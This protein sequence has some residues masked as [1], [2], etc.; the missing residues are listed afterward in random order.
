[1]QSLTSWELPH[2][3][4]PQPIVPHRAQ[5]EIVLWCAEIAL[6]LVD[7][8][9]RV[10]LTNLLAAV[11]APGF[12]TDPRRDE[13]IGAL[14]RLEPNRQLLDYD[15]LLP[16]GL[17]AATARRIANR[18]WRNAQRGAI[19]AIGYTVHALARARNTK[20]EISPEAFIDALDD[21]LVRAEWAGLADRTLT[22]RRSHG[23]AGAR[24]D[25]VLYR[26]GDEKGDGVVWVARLNA[27][28]GKTIAALVR[29][30]GFHYAEGTP[31]DALVIVPDEY[32]A[33]ATAAVFGSQ[34]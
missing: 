9:T 10:E 14:R 4:G 26:A 13:V 15:P 21:K 8:P 5:A 19:Q 17:A 24:L 6:P 33:S 7:A 23:D 29:R 18:S 30:R 1:M 34:A 31:S 16:A 25:A 22:S 11:R 27:G 28:A 2:L 12:A 20:V 32:M 3:G